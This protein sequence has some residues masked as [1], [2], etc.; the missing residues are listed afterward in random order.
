M[1]ARYFC[2]GRG[3]GFL[4]TFPFL[5]TLPIFCAPSRAKTND[6]FFGLETGIPRPLAKAG[7]VRLR[8]C[9]K[10]QR[11]TGQTELQNDVILTCS[12]THSRSSCPTVE[13]LPT[14]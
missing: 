13:R 12:A 8:V 11:F 1:T 5:R 4:S 2:I 9:L 14:V 3:R 6:T 10:S 7:A